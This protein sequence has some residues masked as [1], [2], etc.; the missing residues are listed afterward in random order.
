MRR[1]DG[2]QQ[3]PTMRSASADLPNCS[4]R[5]KVAPAA[6]EVSAHASVVKGRLAYGNSCG[7]ACRSL[8]RLFGYLPA[9][10]S[11][12]PSNV[13][14]YTARK[15]FIKR[16]EQRRGQIDRHR[17]IAPQAGQH[18]GASNS[19]HRLAGFPSSQALRSPDWLWLVLGTPTAGWRDHGLSALYQSTVLLKGKTPASRSEALCCRQRG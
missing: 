11:R 15:T 2:K 1:G 6:K 9:L 4:V 10:P 8:V 5:G 7:N 13:P 17:Q 18:E 12:H 16:R 19:R 14:D 3:V